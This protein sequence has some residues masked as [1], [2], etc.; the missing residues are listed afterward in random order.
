MNSL[1]G[2]S[3]NPL[4]FDGVPSS[5]GDL[6]PVVSQ[7]SGQWLQNYGAENY[8]EDDMPA[9]R[10]M[11]DR[12]AFLLTAAL[13]LAAAP[14]AMADK[15]DHERAR[16]ALQQGQIRPVSEIL[17]QL[18]AQLGGEV[19]KLELDHEDGVYIYEFKVLAADGRVSEVHVDAATG[20]VIKRKP[21]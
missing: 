16:Q 14:A 19:I 4:P 13:C 11:L 18:K 7:L 21:T 3:G 10:P 15:D 1:P 17:S 2:I 6:M 8:D 12:H 5:D 20:K 9:R